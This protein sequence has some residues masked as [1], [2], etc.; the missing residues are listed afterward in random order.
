MEQCR[1]RTILNA[2]ANV[3]RSIK[4]QITDEVNNKFR[5]EYMDEWLNRK[6]LLNE[7]NSSFTSKYQSTTSPTKQNESDNIKPTKQKKKR[8]QNKKGHNSSLSNEKSLHGEHGTE[9]KAQPEQ[10][11]AIETNEYNDDGNFYAALVEDDE[12][13]VES[14]YNEFDELNVEQANVVTEYDGCNML[15]APF[16][17]K[18]TESCQ[19]IVKL[20]KQ[21]ISGNNEYSHVDENETWTIV[22]NKNGKFSNP[23]NSGNHDL[24]KNKSITTHVGNNLM[25]EIEEKITNTDTVNKS[26]ES[27]RNIASKNDSIITETRANDETTCTTNPMHITEKAVVH[28]PMVKLK[29]PSLDNEMQCMYFDTL[30]ETSDITLKYDI[31]KKDMDIIEEAEKMSCTNQ[32]FDTNEHKT[33]DMANSVNMFKA[34]TDDFKD[35]GDVLVRELTDSIVKAFK[36]LRKITE[37]MQTNS[38]DLVLENEKL[39][40]LNQGIEQRLIMK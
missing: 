23:A 24:I 7:L 28:N 18:E 25:N 38:V 6:K 22:S 30:Q 34:Q 2:D 15:S 8:R 40:K 9:T 19:K 16:L 36:P 31:V 11:M 26:Q 21:T 32:V 3:Y 4:Q 33:G 10:Q 13:G 14:V 27:F 37:E 17:Q 1:P 5:N 12:D 20:E 39:S 29:Q 35:I